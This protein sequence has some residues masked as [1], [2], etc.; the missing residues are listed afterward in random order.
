MKTTALLLM[1]IL[2]GTSMAQNIDTACVDK[3][4]SNISIA[5]DNEWRSADKYSELNGI[6]H[7]SFIIDK[8]KELVLEVVV[9]GDNATAFMVKN[10]ISMHGSAEVLWTKNITMVEPKKEEALCTT[11]R[12]R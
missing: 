7:A 12:N 10:G 5:F 11:Q 3:V 8:Q 2:C 9:N 6:I 1:L 4:N